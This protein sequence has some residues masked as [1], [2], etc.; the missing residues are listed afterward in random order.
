MSGSSHTLIAGVHMSNDITLSHLQQLPIQMNESGSIKVTVTDGTHTQPT[1]DAA[2][3]AGYAYITDGTHTQPTMDAASRA[4]Y[5]YITDGTHTAEINTGNA[6]KVVMSP[7]S[8]PMSAAAMEADLGRSFHVK[9]ELTMTTKNTE[10]NLMLL[11]NPVGSGKRIF[12]RKLV[13]SNVT[14]AASFSITVSINPTVTS[15][16]TDLTIM[17]CN[18]GSSITSSMLAKN[19][20]VLV[21]N[22]GSDVI[23]A[24]LSDQGSFNFDYGFILTPGY[25]ILLYGRVYDNSQHIH[26]ALSFSEFSI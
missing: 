7:M 20:S 3:R 23:T 12:L 13:A 9:S 21:S 5:A 18:T 4:G 19:S 8:I 16:G 17:N 15:Y 10:Y 11:Q 2:S 14:S 26:A 25:S 6:L 1:M 24:G 22:V